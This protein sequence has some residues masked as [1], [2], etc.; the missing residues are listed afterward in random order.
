MRGT[1]AVSAAALILLALA[2]LPAG[3]S[4]E[5]E[6]IVTDD[7]YVPE[8]V[9]V[10]AGSSIT[11]EQ[12][13][14]NPHS[15]TA[16]DNSFDSHPGCSPTVTTACMRNGDTFSRVFDQLGTFRYYCK[17]HGSPGGQGMAGTVRVV[18]PGPPV[19]GVL[20][21]QEKPEDPDESYVFWKGG[22]VGD[23][24]EHSLPL[25][26]DRGIATCDNSP[27]FRYRLEVASVG[28]RLR[29]AI[30]TV[31]RNDNFYF[32]VKAPGADS[33]VFVRNGNAF[34]AEVF[35]DNPPLGTYDILVRP[36]SASNTEFAM[37]AKLEANVPVPQPDAEG[38]LLPDLRPTAPYEF[39]FI[40]PANPLNG[41]FPPDDLNPPLDVAGHPISCA[42][43]ETL[44]DGTIK[45][46]RFSFGLTNMGPGNFDIRWTTADGEMSGP[47]YQCVQHADG[48]PTS[49][50][51]GFFQ[52]HTT[53]FHTHYKDIIYLKLFRVTDP[54]AGQTTA[55][56]D[57]R[58][59]GYSPADQALA[60]WFRFDQAERATSG[61]AGNCIEEIDP[62]ANRLGMSVGWGDV[63]R[64]QRPGNYVNFGT[65]PDG[66]YVVRLTADPL[67]NVLEA[68]E[69]NNTSYTYVEV[70]GDLIEVLEYGRGLDPWDPDKQVL[71][72][73]YK[74]GVPW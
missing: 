10:E 5:P 48:P 74:G 4:G 53:H 31:A 36:Y 40:A 61:S 22:E 64:Y 67:D 68:D 57:G 32:E 70:T 63:Y 27:C 11:W 20:R 30:D 60:D 3:A 58:K 33:P 8:D 66:L 54:A 38:R 56:G 52:F 73:R 7:Y 29:V 24:V 55:T 25:V 18:E 50:G 23:A 14:N 1:R 65:N 59:I 41:I 72:P 28:K 21:L 45:C 44:D 19:V 69:G 6:V 49:R 17:V 37:R 71:T 42:V 9:V 26:G 35:I 34:N 13:G 43:D 46:L 62:D 47:M 12:Q 2:P 39:G 15:V 51:A 16:D